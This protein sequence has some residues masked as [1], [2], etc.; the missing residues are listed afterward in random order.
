MSKKIKVDSAKAQDL[1]LNQVRHRILQYIHHRGSVTVKEIAEALSDIPQA[2]MYRQIKA[3]SEGGLI[4]VCGRKRIRGTLEHTYRLSD[5]LKPD[6]D[7]ATGDMSTR[8]ALLSLV[9]D[10]SDYYLKQ[11]ADPGRDMLDVVSRPLLMTD[12]EFEEY[13]SSISELTERYVH[14]EPESDRRIRRVTFISSPA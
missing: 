6:G 3:L 4:S 10:F 7:H 1:M 8:F 9:Q 2:T 5:E 11:D 14:N 13:L 12:E